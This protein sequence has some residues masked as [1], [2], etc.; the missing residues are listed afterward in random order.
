MKYLALIVF[1]FIVLLSSAIC[2]TDSS[3]TPAKDIPFPVDSSRLKMLEVSLFGGP[4]IPYLPAQLKDYTRSAWNAGG[5]IGLVF[6]PGST[7]YGAI[8]LG[9][10]VNRFA[11]DYEK[12]R[13]EFLTPNSFISRNPSFM[14]DVLLNFRGT[15]TSVSKFFHP[16]FVVGVGY[17]HD[18]RGDLV[19]GV[20]TTKNDTVTTKS[21]SGFAWDFGLG[22]DIPV[23]SSFGVYFEGK[24]VLGVMNPTQQYFPI[25]GGIRYRIPR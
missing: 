16:Y 13:K 5:N 7:G 6:S 17:F 12:Y 1:S 22:F 24:S 21:E 8:L 14:V 9:V 10:H 4:T 18:S 20:T 25:S 19:Y 23:T 15:V 3:T 11:F 2:Q